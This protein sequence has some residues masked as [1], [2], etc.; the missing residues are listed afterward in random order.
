MTFN[1]GRQK[2]PKNIEVIPEGKRGSRSHGHVKELP[3]ER[4]GT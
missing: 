4:K 3:T 2:K 1:I